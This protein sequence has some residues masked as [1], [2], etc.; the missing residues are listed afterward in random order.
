MN[1]S[2]MAAHHVDPVGTPLATHA[3]ILGGVHMLAMSVPNSTY[4]T[5]HRM[6]QFTC[7]DLYLRLYIRSHGPRRAIFQSGYFSVCCDFTQKTSIVF[8]G[9]CKLNNSFGDSLISKL[10][11]IA[12]LESF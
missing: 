12:K 2:C 9:F 8:P 6:N 10:A 3:D 4:A 1:S 11:F 5:P 7:F